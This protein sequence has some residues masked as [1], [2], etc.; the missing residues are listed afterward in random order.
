LLHLL[1]SDFFGEQRLA[2]L[3]QSLGAADFQSLNLSYLDGPRLTLSELRGSVEAMPFLG[4]RRMVVVRRLFPSSAGRSAD[5][6]DAPEAR[7]GKAEAE[8]DREFLAYLPRV[9]DFTIL[10]LY[11]DAD[12]KGNHPAV[13]VVRDAGG[14]ALPVAAP[15][16]DDLPRWIGERVRM[17]GGRID[18]PALEDLIGL[19]VDDFRQ[20]DQTLDKLVTYADTR[21][22]TSADVTALVPQGREVTVFALVDAVGSRDRRAALE[23]Y[24]RL[25]ADN[26][27]PIF[28][29]VMLTRQIRLLL[30]AHDAQSRREDLA[31]ALRVQPWVARKIGQ[32]ARG[33]SAERCVQAYRRLAEVDASIKTGQADETIAVELLL[34]DLTER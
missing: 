12:F 9:P 4:D 13:K 8:R 17:K 26:V 21:A 1:R 16:P 28:L 2:E 18:R 22:I 31:A 33:F 25:L 32:Q 14:E 23:T 20:L 5:D 19:G 7:R 11:E 6:G 15:A 30:G 3:K 29:L 34:V 10:V 27:S 24:R